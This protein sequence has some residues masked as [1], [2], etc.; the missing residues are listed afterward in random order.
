MKKK[1]LITTIVTVAMLTVLFT[2]PVMA[3]SRD[4]SF[5]LEIA[6]DADQTQYSGNTLKTDD[7][8]YARVTYDYSNI[9][10]ND[11]IVFYVVGQQGDY[12]EFSERVQATASTGTY[13]PVYNRGEDVYNGNYYRLAGHTYKYYVVV[14]GNWAP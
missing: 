1:K 2:I 11:D 7:D 13:Y 9:T 12:T 3:E 14:S 8:D 4:F 6:E 5:R 10:S